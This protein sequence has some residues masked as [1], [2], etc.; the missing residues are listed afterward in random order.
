MAR[1]GLIGSTNNKATSGVYNLGDVVSRQDAKNSL[2]NYSYDGVFNPL[3]AVASPVGF[4][5]TP[6]GSTMY[7]VNSPGTR[8]GT[9]ITVYTFGSP[10]DLS[11]LTSTGI[12]YTVGDYDL[13]MNS[14]AYDSSSGHL[15]MSGSTS[16]N[17]WDV[18][19]SPNIGE[20]V[21]NNKF[22]VGT[23][24]ATQQ[25]LKIL[26]STDGSYK[27]YTLGTTN[28]R[29]YQYTT[30]DGS[31]GN[32]G[33]PVFNTGNYDNKSF[34]IST[35]SDA[36]PQGIH[37]SP[38]GSSMYM[39]GSTS[40]SIYSHTLSTP[41]DVSTATTSYVSTAAT[42]VLVT[43]QATTQRNDVV[44]GNNGNTMYVLAG[45][46]QATDTVFQ[47]NVGIAWSAPTATFSGI[48]TGITTIINNLDATNE[49]LFFKSDGSKMYVLGNTNDIVHSYTL[50]TPWN[51]GTA[52]SDYV[53][54]SYLHSAQTTTQSKVTFGDNGTKM[55]VLSGGAAV[56]DTVF[57][58]TLGTAWDVTTATYSGLSTSVNAQD[59]TSQGIAFDSTGS[60]M[61]M[62]G[63][64]TDAVYQ[65]SLSTP[66]KIDT[67]TALFASSSSSYL[68]SA[69]TTSTS[70]VAF[71]DNETKMYVLSG[72]A[73]TT[74]TVF[75]YTLST[76]GDV[77][78]ATYASKSLVVNAQD[79]TS[80]GIFFKSDGTK[81][82]MIGST[83][84]TIHS[85][86]LVTPWDIST[87]V[88]ENFSSYLVSA[89]TTNTSKVAI[90]DSGSKMY[91]LA[92]GA[93]A[94]DTVF[95]YTLGT[96]WDVTTASYSGLSAS[97]NTQDITSQGIFFK[98]DGSK[99]YMIG[100]TQDAIFS[101][102]L[103]T[104]WNI[105][106]AGADFTTTPSSF[107]V[108]AQTTNTT[109]VAIGSSGTRMYVLAGGAQAT[110]TVFQYNL[111]TAWDVTTATYS[112][113][114]T[115]VNAQDATSQGIFF[116][117]D[118][119]AMYMVGSTSDIIYQ[120]SLGTPWVI[121]TTSLTGISTFSIATRET[122]ARALYISPDGLN[123]YIGGQTNDNIIQFSLGTPWQ[124]STATFVRSS[125]TITEA[126][127]TGFTFKSDGSVLY[128]IGNTGLAIREYALSIPWD[129]STIS[130][131]KFTN[132]PYDTVPTSILFRDDGS[133]MYISG[134]TNDRVYQ[135][136]LTQNWNSG[137]T[138]GRLYVG[139]RETESRAMYLSSD[140]LNLY[141]GGQTNDNVIQYLLGTAWDVSTAAYVRS[142]ISITEA[143]QT[144]LFFKSD[145]TILYVIGNT[146]QAIREYSLSVAWDVSTISLTRT[147]S[148]STFDTVPTSIIF[149]DDG[150]VMYISGDTNDRIYQ[151]GLS[152]SWNS[153]A[154]TLGKFFIGDRET[155]ARSMYISSDGLNLYIGGQTNDN[156]IQYLLGT[157]W[158]ITTAT[159]VRSSIN[160]VEATQTGITFTPDGTRLY[161]IG[162]TTQTVREYT[163][164]VAWDVSTISLYSI[165][166]IG[167][168][169]TAPTSIVF[170]G[171]GYKMYISGDT[172]DRI[173]QVTLTVAYWSNSIRGRLYIGDRETEPRAIIYDN[174]AR[175]YILGQTSDAIIRYDSAGSVD[176]VS[177]C[178][179]VETSPNI[180][181]A[182]ATGMYFASDGYSVYFYVVGTT[183][184]RIRQFTTP[185]SANFNISNLQFLR[186]L[187]I[188]F[189]DTAPTTI[190]FKDDGT[191]M[192]VAGDTGDRVHQLPLG[193]AW[194]C[195]NVVGRL[196]VGNEETTPT[197]MFINPNG[198]YLYI[199]GQTSDKIFSYDLSTPWDISTGNNDADGNGPKYSPVLTEAT[200]TGI[201]FSSDGSKV[202]VV[203]STGQRISEYSLSFPWDIRNFS[204]SAVRDTPIGF[205]DT[206]PQ[207]IYFKDDGTSLYIM[208]NTNGRVYQTNLTSA[209]N[210]SSSLVFKGKYYVGEKETEPRAIYI[211]P[212]G[213]N[214][215][216]SGQTSDL[217]HQYYL[218]T[219][220]DIN[221]AYF[222]RS[223][224]S[225][226][227]ATM[228]DFYF[229][230][231]G[232]AMWL[233]GSTSDAI[234]Y[235]TMST[236][237]NVSTLTFV[238][239]TSIGFEATPS[240]I[241]IYGPNS[242]NQ[243]TYV[244][245]TT[246][247][248]IY[249]LY[250]GSGNN[251]YGSNYIGATEGT[252]RGLA[253]PNPSRNE[254]FIGGSTG[255]R[256]LTYPNP[257]N[258]I[259]LAEPATFLQSYA[260]TGGAGISF[261]WNGTKLYIATFDTA[262]NGGRQIRQVD[263]SVPYDLTTA[264]LNST[265]LIALYGLTGAITTGTQAI[266]VTPDSS[267]MFVLSSVVKGLYQFSLK[268]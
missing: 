21:N 131:T 234:R 59:A 156:V 20:G 2:S 203:G 74:D 8:V 161:V 252:V 19:G 193:T 250:S 215:F 114:S 202:F 197:G 77:T 238:S 37:I 80:Q 125:A 53:P 128:V 155:E 148:V 82:Y 34:L 236:P 141:I 224:A 244:M 153:S 43:A 65:Y 54:K 61:Y 47:Y 35:A 164:S 64:T 162:T 240:G 189:L 172:G 136:N 223:S 99:M 86:R 196:Y 190:T 229:S 22:Y 66:W 46:T 151:I 188:T 16:D 119:T 216:I 106:T 150:S 264:V 174:N 110:D 100:S 205:I 122:E 259:N 108:S 5:C 60:Y 221:S 246:N 89:Q 149:K 214:M 95:Q 81:M 267:R 133:R 266:Y 260:F 230:G 118:G 101:Y 171:D 212:D 44:F 207:G 182:T 72:G 113:L 104:P 58:Y 184:Q 194:R 198:L 186:E 262:A 237:W 103:S 63:S 165:S 121:N 253:L 112:G 241:W 98:S 87:G 42:S 181:E 208:G 185:V 256:K 39:V 142:S 124:I 140:G 217:I 3:N 92:G 91:V 176:V 11:T 55:Y 93:Q 179:Y 48:G 206:S 228:T 33:A 75:Q 159:Y 115:S 7:I 132:V 249:R 201:H 225:I 40:D 243:Y 12:A 90:G 120:Y 200:A 29:V 31:G 160:I 4:T 96:A 26:P 107:L 88:Y 56:T 67:A 213:Y 247:D 187:P 251:L 30:Y 109:K 94:T 126:T 227:E 105:S 146:G 152:Q 137:A 85:Y 166:P 73:A 180:G 261:N 84:D 248:T 111:G 144:G 145:G 13:T 69:Q 70:K 170:N 130:L 211:S 222:V 265:E 78:T 143:T 158:D 199:V 210:T 123:L 138:P 177:S 52:T 258:G 135:I 17:I 257:T 97:V 183:G 45:G 239:A 76:P 27:I 15:L 167:H 147:P 175:Y 79:A 163:L 51:V 232:T 14:V 32:G 220:G 71:G 139:D 9:S 219:P 233:I 134:D 36:T 191:V 57:Q 116:K 168:L 49:S 102:T 23:Q 195:T 117:T 129:V 25:S 41:Y 242:G 157:A 68:V 154:S 83:S 173:H 24:D 231:D 50:G 127:Q 263:L 10:F 6:D 268:F 245:G 204:I 255:V 218:T 254:I 235:Y 38:D 28:K 226:V 1:L 18:I 192:Y 178:Y 169:D 209:W 62:V